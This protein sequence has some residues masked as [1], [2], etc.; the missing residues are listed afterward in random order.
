LLELLIGAAFS[1]WRAVFL[2]ETVRDVVQIHESEEGFL[3]KVIT[4]NAVTF[5]DDQSNRHWTVEYYF[6]ER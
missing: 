2:A 6:G 5:A 4:H 3:L 1:L